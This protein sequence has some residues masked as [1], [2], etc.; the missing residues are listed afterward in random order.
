MFEEKIDD[1]S[2]KD[3]S[4][5]RRRD[6]AETCANHL[7][8]LPLFDPISNTKRIDSDDDD[9]PSLVPSTNPPPPATPS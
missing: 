6:L 1:H 2:Q 3:M 8:S 4:H 7:V 5:H 9:A